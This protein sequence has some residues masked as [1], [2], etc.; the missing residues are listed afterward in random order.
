MF[1][2]WLIS[3]VNNSVSVCQSFN[4][5]E[6]LSLIRDRRESEGVCCQTFTCS[7]SSSR[8]TAPGLCLSVCLVIMCGVV[9]ELGSHCFTLFCFLYLRRFCNPVH[10]PDV[11]SASSDHR[12]TVQRRQRSA[13]HRFG[14]SPAVPLLQATAAP[15]GLI[16][17]LSVFV[18]EQ[19][20][21]GLTSTLMSVFVLVY[22]LCR[23]CLVSCRNREWCYFLLTGPDSHW[24]QRVCCCTCRLVQ[25][26][27]IVLFFNS[28]MALASQSDWF[29][30]M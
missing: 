29:T 18:T 8:T 21:L 4:P 20:R 6:K 22:L 14:P 17:N 7:N 2:P 27:L 12:V 23:C 11:H 25:W 16:K 10:F 24:W 26:R 5:A 13:C 28:F 15:T 3:A 19:Q 1:C 30:H 9:N